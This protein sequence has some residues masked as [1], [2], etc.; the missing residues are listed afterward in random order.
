MNR[1]KK[2]SRMSGTLFSLSLA[3]FAGIGLGLFYF[4]SL[5]L[6]VQRLPDSRSPALLMFGSFLVRMSLTLFGL[7][8]VMHGSWKRLTICVAGLLLSRMLIVRRLSVE[9][10]TLS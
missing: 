10:P 6:T 7:F 2:R 1:D 9:H 3:L 4:G 8:L 5:W